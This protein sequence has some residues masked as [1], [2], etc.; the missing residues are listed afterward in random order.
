M[1]EKY[2]RGCRAA[3][4][5]RE[6][7]RPSRAPMVYAYGASMLKGEERAGWL[8]GMALTAAFLDRRWTP[9]GAR[10]AILELRARRAGK[11]AA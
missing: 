10:A 11:R 4:R 1:F 3:L 5:V 2:L 9:D 6:V 7:T 8:C